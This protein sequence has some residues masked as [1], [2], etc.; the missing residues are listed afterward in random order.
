M[1]LYYMILFSRNGFPLKKKN[2]TV[3]FRLVAEKEKF[4]HQSQSQL[5]N[6]MEL[7]EIKDV[8]LK[9]TCDQMTMLKSELSIYQ[10]Q[11]IE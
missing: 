8:Q 5:S 10:A 9:A 3:Y 4:Q 11:H 6:L 7:V 2:T 1:K